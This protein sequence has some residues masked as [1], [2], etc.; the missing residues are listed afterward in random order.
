[1]QQDKIIKLL[2][3]LIQDATIEYDSKGIII[4][5][6]QYSTNIKIEGLPD[7][8]YKIEFALKTENN[9]F[10]KL[11]EN[12][13]ES[14]VLPFS[15]MERFFQTLAEQINLQNNKD[16]IEEKSYTEFNQKKQEIFNV[17]NSNAKVEEE[18]QY[19]V[20][21]YTKKLFNNIIM[22]EKNNEEEKVFNHDFIKINY[23]YI[24]AIED[25]NNGLDATY[26]TKNLKLVIPAIEINNYTILKNYFKNPV[27]NDYESLI[28]ILKNNN[29][30]ENMSKLLLYTKLDNKLSDKQKVK[31]KKI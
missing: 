25:D 20:V 23:T 31:S 9:P 28:D 14:F 24:D 29:Q 21:P 18:F 10:K 4:K 1:M 11:G 17:L 26:I 19:Y 13:G 15:I 6:F 30:D 22:I 5:N 8:S 16:F 7:W 3:F 2:E 27:K 12:K